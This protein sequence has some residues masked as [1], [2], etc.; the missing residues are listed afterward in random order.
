MVILLRRRSQMKSHERQL[1]MRG[2]ML[3][4]AVYQS[5]PAMHQSN[6]RENASIF[7]S[8]KSRRPKSKQYL[9]RRKVPCN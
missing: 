6:F 7:S 8:A 9:R 4:P 1:K 3:K 2:W 5:K